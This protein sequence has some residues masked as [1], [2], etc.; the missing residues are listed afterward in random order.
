MAQMS[1]PLRRDAEAKVLGRALYVDDLCPEDL[2]YGATIRT[3]QPGGTLGN[4]ELNPG[5][6]WS[7][8]VV[9]T[10]KDIPG[11]N[12]VKMIE[13]DQ[14]ILVDR[15]Y[16]HSGEAVLLLA[17]PNRDR[18]H[19]AMDQITV[20]ENP[21]RPP[22]WNI[23]D[24]LTTANQVIPNNTYTEYTLVKGE[25]DQ[26]A[27]NC[28][29]I[30]E[31]RVETPS[32]E[33]L[34]IEPQGMLG[35]LLSDGRMLVQGSMQCPYYV[36][37]A[38]KQCLGWEENRIQVVQSTT[39]GAFGG[40]EDYPSMIACHVA[41]L[42]LHAGGRP[43]KLIYERSED[44][45]VTPKRHPSR[46]LVRLGANDDGR[47]CLIDM[48]F[49]IDGGAYRTLSPVV[50]SRGVIHAPGPYRC[51]N[52][53]VRG[54]AVFTNHPP[55][56]AFR[57]FGAPQS[58]FALEVAMDQLAAKLGIDPVELRRMNLLQPGDETATGDIQS[59]DCFA[60]E[61]LEVA[62]THS[63][64]AE[65]H[66]EYQRWN[67]ANNGTKRGIGLACFAHGAGFTGNGEIYLA[68]RV[69]LSLN[70]DG[71]VEILCSN[72][73]MGQ[74][75]ATTL[76]QIAAE[77]LGIPFEYVIF[78]CVDTRRVPNSGPTVASRTCMVVGGLIAKA[79]R[80]LRDQLQER[81]MFV[82]LDE[83]HAESYLNACRKLTALS[84]GELRIT[85]SY[86]APAGMVWDEKQFR[87]RAY[88]SYAWATYIAEVEIDLCT[89]DIRLIKFTAVQE[90][91]RAVHPQIARGQIEGGVVQG[92]GW[93]LL[94]NIVWN[95]QGVM[96]NN[97]LTNYI[98]PT[99]A[100][101]GKIDVVFLENGLGAGPGGAKGLGE[102]PMDGPAPAIVNAIRD[103]LGWAPV[104]LPASPESLLAGM[105]FSEG[106]E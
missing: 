39:G 104:S 4:I 19:A 83:F 45:Q 72:T 33:Q 61:V 32:Q 67:R 49:A 36:L 9:I 31:L 85:E 41:L 103:A 6:D 65:K 44:L 23:D 77:N 18:L 40:K 17:H 74:G 28:I 106:I 97:R 94:E 52:V 14:P 68:S 57:G 34:Y 29:H 70:E 48:D 76:S 13:D 53:S 87:G 60:H 75:A 92:I 81:G 12:A 54:R 90:I 26:V 21:G 88:S 16:R 38:L 43:V 101:I 66:A 50:L 63:C 69:T 47:L 86:Q 42:A 105:E 46:T 59:E 71:I 89:Y 2:L 15:E 73:E 102:L 58:I 80:R 56:G 20:V 100:D 8:F 24:A 99:S 55:F 3:R 82:H 22:I 51:P 93:A 11:K 7:G 91:G 10:A 64:F 5:W 78:P 98:I 62:L 25:P 37:D 96:A 30:V 1:N 79:A 95:Q 84:G 27:K 35:Q